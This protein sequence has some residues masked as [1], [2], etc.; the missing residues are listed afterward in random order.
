MIDLALAIKIIILNVKHTK[1]AMK[2]QKISDW[3][4]LKDSNKYITRDNKVLLRNHKEINLIRGY[5]RP[6]KYLK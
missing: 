2:R 3:I 1:T 6:S 4:F 5:N